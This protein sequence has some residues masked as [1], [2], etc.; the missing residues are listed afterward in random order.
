MATKSLETAEGGDKEGERESPARRRGDRCSKPGTRSNRPTLFIRQI[1]PVGA[2][3]HPPP[4]GEM[5]E[6]R[7]PEDPGGDGGKEPRK[8]N[9][10]K[11]PCSGG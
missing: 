10:W 4:D 1:S 3:Q 8:G 6:L 11:P 2:Q 9:C 5:A 7:L